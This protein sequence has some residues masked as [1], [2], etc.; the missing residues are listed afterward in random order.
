MKYHVLFINL[1]ISKWQHLTN[2]E[3]GHSRELT[4]ADESAALLESKFAR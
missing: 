2:A 3:Y 4:I 1:V